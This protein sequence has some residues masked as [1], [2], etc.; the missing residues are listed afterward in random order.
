MLLKAA[1]QNGAEILPLIF[2][3]H[4]VVAVISAAAFL[5]TRGEDRMP[6]SRL[7]VL[8]FLGGGTMLFALFFIFTALRMGDLTVVI[9]ITQFA[10]V[11][12]AAA[13]AVVFKEQIGVLRIAAIVL[14]VGSI[15]A[16]G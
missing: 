13:S 2:S 3:R 14:A 8:A 1:L 16:I 12:S 7:W 10:F 5:L 6:G 15:L 9:P 11:F 4:I